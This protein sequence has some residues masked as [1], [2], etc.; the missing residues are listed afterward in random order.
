VSCTIDG[1]LF[2]NITD[3][4]QYSVLVCTSHDYA[5]NC[6]AVFSNNIIRTIHSTN[7][8]TQ[9]SGTFYLR[10]FKWTGYNNNYSGITTTG[11]VGFIGTVYMVDSQQFSNLTLTNDTFYNITNAGNGV[12]MFTDS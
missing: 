5:A 4:Y 9:Y 2:E 10:N 11:G 8:S 6:T 1:C 7:Q 12:G 3:L